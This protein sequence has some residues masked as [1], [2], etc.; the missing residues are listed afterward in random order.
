LRQ[1]DDQTRLQPG[2]LSALL[3]EL[4]AAPP[5][6]DLPEVPIPSLRPGTVIGRFEV[7][8]E[9]GRG[10]FGVVY[11]AH[12]QGLL[13]AVA[14]KLVRAGRASLGEG[15]LQREAE[16][17]A[18]LSHPNLVTLFDVGQSAFGPYLVLE[19]LRGRTL[20][21][22][23]EEG[24]LPLPEALDIALQIARGLAHAHGNGVVH[25]DLKP[26]NVFLCERGPLKLLDFGMSHA[27]GRQRVSGGTPAFMAPE[28]WRG[29]PEDERTDVFALGLLLHRMLT[30][31]LPWP[32]DGGSAVTGP[33]AAPRLAVP[34]HP[35]LGRLVDRMLAKDVAK[36]PR[37]GAEVLTALEAMAAQT[38]ARPA[39]RRALAWGGALLAAAALASGLWALRG[40][41]P[42][43]GPPPRVAVA[44][45]ANAT[46]DPGLDDLAG[47]L[48]TALEQSRW[49]EVLPRSRQVDLLQEEGREAVGRI[50]EGLGREI[51][52]RAGAALVL[53][54]IGR[55]DEVYAVDLKVVD[56]TTGAL[57]LAAHGEAG[58]KAA[59]PTT[60]DQ[61]AARV[62]RG[63]REVAAEPARPE[64]RM[65][66]AVTNLEAYRHYFRGMELLGSQPAEGITE[67][68]EALAIDPDFPLAHYG[69]SWAY[70]FYGS[71]ERGRAEIE[72]AL[73]GAP[74][75][76]AKERTLVQAWKLHLDG[77]EEEAHALY[78]EAAQAY[79]HDKQVQL[80]AAQLYFNEGDIGRSIPYYERARALGQLDGVLELA[81]GYVLTGR[82]AE[83]RTLLEELGDKVS[84]IRR[85]HYVRAL[86]LIAT[87]R[88][89]E[90]IRGYPEARQLRPEERSLD[91]E[92]QR[93]WVLLEARHWRE[94]EARA[95]TLLDEG[96]APAQE[97][98][99]H[100]VRRAVPA[101]L[102][103]ALVYQGRFREA[104]ELLSLPH[105][106][107]ML[108]T[109]LSDRAGARRA[110]D[111][112]LA[113]SASGARPQELRRFRHVAPVLLEYLGETG[114]ALE[115]AALVPD[116]PARRYHRAL[117]RWRAGGD[118][119]ELQALAV[120]PGFTAAPYFL[121]EA[122]LGQG[123]AAGAARE[124]RR[125]QAG[126]R[127]GLLG[128]DPSRPGLFDAWAFP[129][130][131]LLLARA[132]LAQDD[133]SGAAATLAAL[134][135]QWRQADPDLPALAEARAL[136]ARVGAR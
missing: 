136:A 14:F 59:I 31:A 37:D 86:A 101:P 108:L 5:P 76:P 95:R 51:A 23:L 89:E 61:L 22:R 66:S 4:A 30:G 122:L 103:V 56:P 65:A 29:D 19:L 121:G 28:Q 64:V 131:H 130:S 87:G 94:A 2:T 105:E 114:R 77:R 16:A 117:A 75:L 18:R 74:R 109:G 135:E 49:L 113:T 38:P 71:P 57:L 116:V 44:D 70:E 10:G 106:R 88:P 93:I 110:V 97:G 79:P 83:A 54:S 132:L 62:R 73:A 26:S 91:L 55:F 41:R 123:D 52:R 35:A 126:F 17:I 129:R 99:G 1:D 42:P 15:L 119:S 128:L 12:D 25:R 7:K 78:A 21:Q 82:G 50:D 133:R 111:E 107:A 124:L 69:L 112:A 27:F 81:T 80:L 43:P 53:P 85:V 33:A 9:I 134:L 58:S 13:R 84:R 104:L 115:L 11:E 98:K 68:R 120:E 72:A 96:A 45:M 102:P 100:A 125:F 40:G 36:R 118:L 3:Q 60:I 48:I 6:A 46:G 67:F 24:P 63:L 32:D 20:Q 8:R 39:R 92:L 90:A 47:L 34:E 127:G